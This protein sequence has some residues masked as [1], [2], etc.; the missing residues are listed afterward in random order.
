M[1]RGILLIAILSVAAV[2]S[3]FGKDLPRMAAP[4]DE[5]ASRATLEVVDQKNTIKIT[6]ETF[7]IQGWA[8]TEDDKRES[9]S[10]TCDAAIDANSPL[11]WD[12]A[13]KKQQLEKAILSYTTDKGQPYAIEVANAV[14]AHLSILGDRLQF[15][16]SAASSRLTLRPRRP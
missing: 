3:A 15:E 8:P 5:P 7:E 1:Y 14:I 4:A 9:I 10:V 6:C 11:L 12:Y 2:P 16:L 13:A